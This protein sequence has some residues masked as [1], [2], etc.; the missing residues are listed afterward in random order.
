MLGEWM[1]LWINPE[2][3]RNCHSWRKRMHIR[4]LIITD[5]N[6]LKDLFAW[7][8]K[9][10]K[11]EN[12]GPI[13]QIALN[14]NHLVLHILRKGSILKWAQ[15]SLSWYRL[16]CWQASQRL[17]SASVTLCCHLN[18]FARLAG[19]AWGML[20]KVNVTSPVT[21]LCSWGKGSSWLAW[22]LTS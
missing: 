16:V 5:N 2:T 13:F 8:R 17:H 14:F 10:K 7:A 4:L 9:F 12:W 18:H 21:S 15:E 11:K 22:V 20:G 3:S 19:Q 1:H 6:Y